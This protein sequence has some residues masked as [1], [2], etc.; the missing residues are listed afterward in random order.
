M[1]STPFY[2]LSEGLGNS[3]DWFDTRTK[4][5]DVL[6]RAKTAS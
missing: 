1:A 2:G 3:F 6:K 4:S 5:G